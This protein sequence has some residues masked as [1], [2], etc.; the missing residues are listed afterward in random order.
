MMTLS[1]V[2]F[3]VFD[4]P[5]NHLDVESIEALE[6]A[7]Q[8]YEGTVLLV[9]HDRALLAALCTRIWQIEDSTIRDYDGSFT[10]WE[11][12]RDERRR[13]A[14]VA[15]REAET[16]RR[17]REKQGQGARKSESE[18]KQQ[19]GALRTARR[20]LEQAELAVQQYERQAEAMSDE[21]ADPELYAAPDGTARAARIAKDLERLRV[22]L[23]ASFAAWEAAAAEVERLAE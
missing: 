8:A 19:Q 13:L 14:N 6:D 11:E 10:E 3:L 16:A 12:A 21:L 5:T 20:T 23:K 7:I 18:R 17:A 2:N 4:E 15:S 22:K 1:Q 9:S